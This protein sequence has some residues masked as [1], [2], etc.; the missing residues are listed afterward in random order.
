ML[1]LMA[2]AVA[3]VLW[4]FSASIRLVFVM[5]VNEERLFL[6]VYHSVWML[7]KVKKEKIKQ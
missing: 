2:S 3:Q 5:G 7:Y 1:S 4:L 6:S